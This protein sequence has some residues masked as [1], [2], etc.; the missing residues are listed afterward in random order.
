LLKNNIHFFEKY[1]NMI[2]NS[3]SNRTQFSLE[4]MKNKIQSNDDKNSPEGKFT[5]SNNL[6]TNSKTQ[7][8]DL[9]E[10]NINAFDKSF[11][12]SF[13]TKKSSKKHKLS[14]NISEGNLEEDNYYS[15]II[16]RNFEN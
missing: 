13:N 7:K 12:N 4:E 9:I 16:K 6:K 3:D 10:E 11:I 2:E 5:K 8:K 14:E 1:L 15:D